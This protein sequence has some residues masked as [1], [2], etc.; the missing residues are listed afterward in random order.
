[1]AYWFFCWSLKIFLKTFFNLRRIGMRNIPS[2]G[3]CIIVSNHI[4]FL[5]P[6]AIGASCS[7]RVNFLAR[8]TLFDNYLFGKFLHAVKVIPLTTDSS[9]F[10]GL[11]KALSCL[12]KGEIVALFPQ[13]TRGGS[14]QK[15]K[16]GVGFLAQQTN[17]PIIPAYIKG[18]DKALP[19][20]AKFFKPCS[21]TIYFGK[22]M[23]L[24]ASD[25]AN[26]KE[27]IQRINVEIVKRIEKL[28]KSANEIETT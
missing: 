23:V 10:G 4:S 21:I 16:M 8:K 20:G 13:G 15:A 25:L 17:S 28:R 19:R 24:S 12:K 27:G 22:K 6:G 5:D 1:M 26:K 9:K 3:H 14:W 11:R 2:S 7:R 18:T